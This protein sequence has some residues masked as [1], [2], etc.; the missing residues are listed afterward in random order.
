MIFAHIDIEAVVQVNDKTRLNASKSFSNTIGEITL[1]EIQPTAS[2]SFYDVTSDLYLD[3]SYSTDGDHVATVRI[4]GTESQ[5]RTISVLSVADDN[6][7]SVD[8]DIISYEPDLLKW[9]Q[10]GRNSFLDKHRAAQ[11]EI[12]NE[13]DANQIW[14]RDGSR[15][16]ATD[17]VDIQEFKEWSKY[18]TLR[19]IF[20][21]ISN[22][23]D[24]VF[25]DKANNYKML[26]V[27]A[28]KRA[29]LRLDYNDDGNI[30]NLEKTN[31][32]TGTLRRS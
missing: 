4:N 16:T 28:K 10:D 31:I 11:R 27:S 21:G 26:V 13:L 23:I 19:I 17:I 2:E 6:L 15:Y 7:F 29:T 30:D 12:L 8:T 14:K 22:A 18:E 20:D 32:F 9:V 5:S 25:K 24:D 3:W 1:V